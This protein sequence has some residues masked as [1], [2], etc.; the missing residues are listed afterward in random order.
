M[1][2][3]SYSLSHE[4]EQEYYS[5]FPSTCHRSQEQ[6]EYIEYD[7]SIHIL[8]STNLQ[9]EGGTG[10]F[11]SMFLSK[12]ENITTMTTPIS[13]NIRQ[14]FKSMWNSMI[15]FLL[16]RILKNDRQCVRQICER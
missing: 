1:M 13:T 10:A 2:K 16:I 4:F 5:P 8:Q 12:R 15:K 9:K 7:T 3:L 14:R 6:D 11:A